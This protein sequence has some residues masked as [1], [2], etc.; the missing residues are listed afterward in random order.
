MDHE[1]KY[2]IFHVTTRSGFAEL[3]PFLGHR[4]V[5]FEELYNK[6]TDRVADAWGNQEFY[7]SLNEY[8][9]FKRVVGLPPSKSGLQRMYNGLSKCY[10]TNAKNINNKSLEFYKKQAKRLDRLHGIE[11]GFGY[12]IKWD[13]ID[14]EITIPN[15][16]MDREFAHTDYHKKGKKDHKKTSEL[17]DFVLNKID[18]FKKN[19]VDKTPF[20]SLGDSREFLQFYLLFDNLKDLLNDENK[21]Y[22]STKA[23]FE[24]RSLK[25]KKNNFF[26]LAVEYYRLA[27]KSGKSGWFLET[28]NHFK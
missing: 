13:Q 5:Y 25:N 9:R 2:D 6:E 14:Q 10:N 15:D 20:N 28:K 11:M 1:D 17:I 4:V 26:H 8:G 23:V 21:L 24:N 12:G 16:L 3:F 18:E 27:K 19:R 22:F 7:D